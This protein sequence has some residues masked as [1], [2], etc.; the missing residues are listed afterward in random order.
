MCSLLFDV[1]YLDEYE[2]YRSKLERHANII[3]FLKKPIFKKSLCLI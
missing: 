1:L 3:K 2:K